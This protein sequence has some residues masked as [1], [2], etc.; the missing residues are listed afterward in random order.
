MSDEKYPQVDEFLKEY[1]E[2]F[3]IF[4]IFGAVSVYLSSISTE[5]RFASF[6][7]TIGIFSSYVIM[8]QV[9][10]MI[11]L[12]IGDKHRSTDVP[13]QKRFN[14]FILYWALIGIIF[15]VISIISEYQSILIRTPSILLTPLVFVLN[16]KIV[17]SSSFNNFVEKFQRKTNTQPPVSSF[18]IHLPVISILS[19]VMLS[20]LPHP[21]VPDKI[22]LGNYGIAEEAITLIASITF[23]FLVIGIVSMSF[24][25]LIPYISDNEE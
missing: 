14:Y 13:L 19:V 10:L 15:A 24:S 25:M 22:Y 9:L 16:L 12:K 2:L 4:G 7:I 3:S 17:R 5:T 18:L 21:A 8:V 23:P 20:T 11:H 6:G 1:S